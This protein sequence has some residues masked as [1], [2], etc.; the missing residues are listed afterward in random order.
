MIMWAANN[1]AFA[2]GVPLTFIVSISLRPLYVFWKYFQLV[3]LRFSPLVV[4]LSFKVFWFI[5]PDCYNPPN[6]PDNNY[7]Y[8]KPRIIF[9]IS[10]FYCMNCEHSD[11]IDNKSQNYFQTYFHFSFEL[12]ISEYCI[13]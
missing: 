8:K 13:N 4:C 1:F 7:Y 12:Y 2:F 5:T 6:G 9:T 3:F 10:V 11:N